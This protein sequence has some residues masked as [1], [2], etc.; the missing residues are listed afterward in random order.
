MW[1]GRRRR[2]G[3]GGGETE[4]EG[5]GGGFVPWGGWGDRK[6]TSVHVNVGDGT[7]TITNNKVEQ[8]NTL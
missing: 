1:G 8:L 7:W 4:S 3:G 6:G 2:G 5:G